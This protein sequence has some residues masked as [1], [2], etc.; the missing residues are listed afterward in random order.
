MSTPSKKASPPVAAKKII[1]AAP[2]V[3]PK[4]VVAPAV[5]NKPKVEAKKEQKETKAAPVVVTKATTSQSSSAIPSTRKP[6]SATKSVVTAKPTGTKS[7]ASTGGSGG[8]GG[9]GQENDDETSEVMAPETK[10]GV[11]PISAKKQNETGSGTAAALAEKKRAILDTK[12]K[13]IVAAA[14]SKS[15]ATKGAGSGG[16]GAG[17]SGSG[18][19]GQDVMFIIGKKSCDTVNWRLLRFGTPKVNDKRKTHCWS[20]PEWNRGRR[21]LRLYIKDAFCPKGFSEGYDEEEKNKPT[22]MITHPRFEEVF[23]PCD[24]YVKP[25]LETLFTNVKGLTNG[26]AMPTVY[27]Y[28]YSAKERDDGT[29]YH[30]VMNAVVEMEG[31]NVAVKNG[32]E[33]LT[34]IDDKGVQV[35]P[36]SWRNMLRPFGCDAIVKLVSARRL[37][38]KFSLKWVLTTLRVRQGTIHERDSFPD[39]GFEEGDE[40]YEESKN[41]D[42]GETHGG[43]GG[44]GGG[45]HDDGGGVE[46]DGTADPDDSTAPDNEDEPVKKNAK[47]KYTSLPADDSVE[48]GGEVEGGGGGDGGDTASRS[49]DT[50]A[51]LQDEEKSNAGAEAVEEGGA[52]EAAPELEAG[53]EADTQAADSSTVVDEEPPAEDAPEEPVADE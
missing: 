17:A 42:G 9:S 43:G 12:Q 27:R 37:A 33:A 1:A 35:D 34:I 53:A 41:T 14:K 32:V 15:T 11:A 18:T 52:E 23:T 5:V 39:A 31:E 49:G 2:K 40:G 36:N 26:K 50:E 3:V 47:A 20:L 7:S 21:Q 25:E 45:I 28:M 16:S 48:D 6:V 13:A 38:E 51:E 19:G 22:L 29:F 44:G 24:E 30:G 46:T 10:K 4:P 8:G